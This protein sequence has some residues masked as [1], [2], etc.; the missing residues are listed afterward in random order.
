MGAAKKS[1]TSQF[2]ET[3]Q[4]PKKERLK[5]VLRI[6]RHEVQNKGNIYTKNTE[7]PFGGE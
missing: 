7:V 5:K 6:V 1:K 2:I 3:P 4:S